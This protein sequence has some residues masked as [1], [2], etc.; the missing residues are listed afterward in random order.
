[1]G[2]KI[3]PSCTPS[4]PSKLSGEGSTVS[5]FA[6]KIVIQSTLTDYFLRSRMSVQ[7]DWLDAEWFAEISDEMKD[8]GRMTTQLVEESIAEKEQENPG[9]SSLTPG[10]QRLTPGGPER[11]AEKDRMVPDKV[12]DMRSHQ[13]TP[14]TPRGAGWSM[15]E[16]DQKILLES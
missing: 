14:S 13:P 4:S 2:V 6:P 11:A 16:D 9:G 3:Q 5:R 7:E 10:E 8:V 15:M 1:M 12:P